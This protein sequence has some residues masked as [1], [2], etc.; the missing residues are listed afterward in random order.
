MFL[1]GCQL[2]FSLRLSLS[3]SLSLCCSLA[4][5]PV[6]LIS[7]STPPSPPLS[8]SDLLCLPPSSVSP[9]IL[10]HIQIRA[11][12]EQVGC[13]SEQAS[14][15]IMSSFQKDSVCKSFQQI[16]LICFS[17]NSICMGFEKQ[18]FFIAQRSRARTMCET[19]SDRRPIASCTAN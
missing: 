16:V 3:L 14:S 11:D 4:P 12:R 13:P 1:T 15:R 7:L 10:S 19:S 8:L 18:T 17:S 6:I 5:P 2:C 9:L